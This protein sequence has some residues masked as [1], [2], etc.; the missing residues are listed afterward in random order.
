MAKKLED[1]KVETNFTVKLKLGD[2]VYENSA[3]TPY[4]AFAKLKKPEKINLKGILFLS[5]GTKTKE[6]GMLPIRLRRLFYSKTQ[7]ILVKSLIL[8]M[9]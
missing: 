4:E 2:K 1:K 3:P 7:S 6:I 8:G 5:D 9:K